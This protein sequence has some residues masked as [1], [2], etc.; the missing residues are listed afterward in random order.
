MREAARPKEIAERQA[1]GL[2]RLSATDV[3]LTRV[4]SAYEANQSLRSLSPDTRHVKK[5]MTTI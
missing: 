4:Q 5:F 3:L 1:R 2:S